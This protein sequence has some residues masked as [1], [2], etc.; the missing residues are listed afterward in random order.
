MQERFIGSIP[1]WTRAAQCRTLAAVVADHR[2]RDRLI[3][4]AVAYETMAA[5]S[6][7]PP[8]T[9]VH[10]PVDLARRLALRPRRSDA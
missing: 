8:Q 1:L 6:G 3:A 4:V 9:I 2:T 5:R 7:Q 10:R